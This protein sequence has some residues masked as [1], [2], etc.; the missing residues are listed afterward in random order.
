MADTK[1]TP[2][3]LQVTPENVESLANKLEQFTQSLCPI[4]RALLM[5]RIKRSMPLSNL[6]ATTPLATSPAVF[7]AWL[8]A[9]VSDVSRWYPQ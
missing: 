5:E 9:I 1:D 4:E 8:N 3:Y 6:D 7:A 2:T